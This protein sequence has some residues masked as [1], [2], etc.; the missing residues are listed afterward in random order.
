M[1]QLNDCSEER[2]RGI[3]IHCGLGLWN[4]G[5]TKDHVPSK[6]LLKSTLPREPIPLLDV[7]QQCNA[8]F[9]KDVAIGCPAVLASVI[10]WLYKS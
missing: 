1:R 7:C 3:C 4:E 9:S 10:R 6:A 8:G 5:R 2:H